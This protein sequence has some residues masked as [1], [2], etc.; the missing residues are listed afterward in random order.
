MNIKFKYLTIAASLLIIS[1]CSDSDNTAPEVPPPTPLP[2]TAVVRVM[3]ASPDAPAVNVLADGGE[4]VSGADY[5][6]VSAP[7]NVDEG[8]YSIQVDGILPGGTVATVI[9]PVDLTFDA[10]LEY[11]VV[12][13]GAVA[14]IEPVLVEK[15]VS[16]VA[17]GNIRVRVM[18]AAPMV[19]EVSVFVTT[20]DADLSGEMP[21]VTAD[22]KGVTDPVEVTAGTYQIRITDPTNVATVA[23]DSGPVDLA[24]GSDL[25]VVAIENTG[26][27]P[28]PVK[29]L[30][31]TGDSFLIINDKAVTAD[32]QAIHASPD[33]PPVNII[34]DDDFITPVAADLPFGGFTGFASTTPGDHNVKVTAANDTVIAIDA[35]LTLDADTTYSIVA[36]DL[37]ATIS[38]IVLADDRRRVVTESKVRIVHASPAAGP[39]DVYVTAPG[40][41][42]T[43]EEPLAPLTNVPFQANTG[44]L[45]LTPGSYD[46]TVVPTGTKDA[47]I[48]P[49]T[50]TVDAAGIYTAIAVDAAGGGA[51]LGLILTDD[52]IAQ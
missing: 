41:D 5:A 46:V 8:T 4:L 12:A 9:G 32:V 3:H 29:L 39:V 22:F 31:Q 45:S 40:A 36:T 15:P 20:P 44:Y 26:T 11:T 10:E 28:S 7:A 37:L 38:P 27:G 21:L 49:A 51:P 13:V 18:H 25:L 24:D 48:G 43:S 50:I 23:F 1:A 6:Q 17:A 34:L 19:G 30:V 14:D 52:F 47:A 42:I 33:A 16:A 35:D 2:E